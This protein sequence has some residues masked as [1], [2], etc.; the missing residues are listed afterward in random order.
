[1]KTQKKLSLLF[2]TIIFLAFSALLAI[3]AFGFYNIG[4]SQASQKADLTTELVKNGLT[5]HMANG[6]MDNRD[7]FLQ[8][9]ENMKNVDE[10]WITRSSSVVKQYGIGLRSELPRDNIDK[11]VLKQ[12]KSIKRLYESTNGLKLRFTVPYTAS[13]QGNIDCMSCHNAKEGE[14][15]GTVSMV[16][17]VSD[18]RNESILTMTYLTVIATLVL[19]LVLFILNK[20]LQPIW[21]LFDSIRSVMGLANSGDY[22]KRIHINEANKESNQVATWI[23]SF[24]NKLENTLDRIQSNAEEFLVSYKHI[25]NDPLLDA[26]KVIVQI[27]EVYRFKKTIEFDTDKATVYKRLATILKNNLNADSFSFF[28]SNSNTGETVCVY[29][30]NKNEKLN[31]NI[32]DRALRTNHFVSSS[33]FEDICQLPQNN[34]QAHYLCAPYSIGDDFDLFIH[35]SFSSLNELEE[36]KKLLPKI[37]NYIDA[38]RPELISKNLT[39]ILRLSSTTDQLTGLYNR[40]FLDEFIEKATSQTMRSNGN[41]GILML[42]IDFFKSVNDTYGH[43]VGDMVIQILSECVLR[44]IRSSDIAFRYGG[45]EFLVML[46]NC[47]DL[48]IDHIAN[49]I[50][51]AFGD[52]EIRTNRGDSFHKTL[53][54][55]YS[56]FPNDARSIW[57]CIKFADIALYKAKQTGRNKV[58]KFTN[59]M[60]DEGEKQAYNN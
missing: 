11:E 29:G 31:E 34:K 19:A 42:D 48:S 39:E 40:K 46:Y 18:I 37:E 14:V 32:K 10:L 25:D 8:N 5:A 12:G 49:K 57:R 7:F 52:E 60:L 3:I 17:D 54:I 2:I 58:V 27:A 26:E 4:N 41:Y 50:R 43:D 28:E 9:I 20:S 56:T 21:E 16:F 23:N 13:S 45:E 59:A 22:S 55:G 24:L 6:M 35:F 30:Y 33:Q 44:S 53:S 51:L 47:N 15:L 38:A 36:T 1:M